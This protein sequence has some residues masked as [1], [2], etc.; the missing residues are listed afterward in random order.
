MKF[1]TFYHVKM[2]MPLEKALLRAKKIKGNSLIMECPTK[3][4]S[5]GSYQ[6]F[7]MGLVDFLNNAVGRE[8]TVKYLHKC[9]IYQI[10]KKNGEI[11]DRKQV[12]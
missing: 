2:P 10:V 7:Y 1:E 12:A 3:D 4:F 6:F 5:P 11:I 8:F 9:E